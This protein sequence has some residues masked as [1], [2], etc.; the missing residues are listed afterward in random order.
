M[1]NTVTLRSAVPVQSMLSH[2][3][4][5]SPGAIEMPRSSVSCSHSPCSSVTLRCAALRCAALGAL[6]SWRGRVAT[7]NKREAEGN[8]RT[9]ERLQFAGKQIEP[10]AALH[11]LKCWVTLNAEPVVETAEADSK[12]AGERAPRRL[13]PAIHHTPHYLQRHTTI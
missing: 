10:A 8:R 1:Y 7:E 4:C 2:T 5:K 12:A 3:D 9:Q 13:H 6:V 11:K